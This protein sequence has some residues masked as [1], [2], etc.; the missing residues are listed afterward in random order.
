M[1]GYI[2]IVFILNVIDIQ[3]GNKRVHIQL[4]KT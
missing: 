3:Y 2:V 1:L 4:C